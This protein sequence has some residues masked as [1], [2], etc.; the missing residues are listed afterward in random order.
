MSWKMGEEDGEEMWNITEKKMNETG[1]Q[2]N[3]IAVVVRVRPFNQRE[4][5]LNTYK[6]IEM[7][8][9][10]PINNQTWIS[11]PSA[12][13]DVPPTKFR[14]DY[15]FDSFDP[16]ASNFINQETVFR[17][18]GLDILAKAWS[19]YN[20]CLFAYGQTGSGKTYS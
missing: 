15:C 18:V 5:D 1:N 8:A 10:D 14:F 2:S 9:S 20:A 3:N 13:P 6:C 7:K 12:K 4:K 11:D 16:T 17:A 19:G